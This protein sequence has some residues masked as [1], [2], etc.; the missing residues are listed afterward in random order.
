M[1]PFEEGEAKATLPLTYTRSQNLEN[2]PSLTKIV[3]VIFQGECL[4]TM[5]EL[6]TGCKARAR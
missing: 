4:A 3:G 1:I 6:N 2:I 5:P